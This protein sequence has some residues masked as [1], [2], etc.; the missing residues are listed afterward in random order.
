MI[1]PVK[2]V[3]KTVGGIQGTLSPGRSIRSGVVP[4]MVFR[5][6]YYKRGVSAED[7]QRRPNVDSY[8]GD[9]HLT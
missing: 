6:G 5:P 3:D 2:A 8:G 7:L 4:R 9:A 1:G